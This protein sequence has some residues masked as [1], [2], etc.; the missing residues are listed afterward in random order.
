MENVAKILV[1]SVDKPFEFK[2]D[3]TGELITGRKLHYAQLR[4]ENEKGVVGL[5]VEEKCF[6]GKDQ[7]LLNSVTM[8]G[9]YEAKIEWLVRGLRSYGRFTGFRFLKEFKTEL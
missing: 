1:L 3:K 2:D 8:P 7:E 6:M 4:A 5:A 9:Y